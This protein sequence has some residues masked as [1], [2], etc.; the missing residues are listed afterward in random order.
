[1]AR[2]RTSHAHRHVGR[3][4]PWPLA[5]AIAR[6][7]TPIGPRVVV[8]DRV[9]VDNDRAKL[10]YM[11]RKAAEAARDPWIVDL[12]SRLTRPYPADAWRDRVNAIFRFVRDGMRYQRDPGRREQIAHPRVSLERGY[13]DCDDKTM[14]FVALC[15]AIGIEADAW[16]LWKGD[17]L[18]HVQ[19]A[20]RWP[21]SERLTNAQSGA[22]VLDGPAGAGWIVSDATIAGAEL[23]Q[24]ARLVPRNPE[25][26][27]L[28]LA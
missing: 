21:G 5:R 6:T 19:Q 17:E 28:P 11:R 7:H 27:K 24:D 10:R 13:G 9:L 4:G 23:G 15:R 25:T 1:M 20:A 14:A 16:P 18:V 26:G 3:G 2:P 8:V 22:E 12:A